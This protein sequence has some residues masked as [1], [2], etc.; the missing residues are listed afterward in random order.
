MADMF[1]MLKQ[2]AAMRQQVKRIQKELQKVSVEG[3]SGFVRVTMLGDM[4]MKSVNID[5]QGLDQARKER[6]ESQIVTAV[7]NAL[8]NAKKQAGTEM[9]KMTGGMGGLSDLLGGG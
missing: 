3:A 4:T 7:N 9:G 5:P 1:K 6:L 2:A 8:R